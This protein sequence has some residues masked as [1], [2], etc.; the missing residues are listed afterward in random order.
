VLDVM[1]H[2]VYILI[3]SSFLVVHSFAIFACTDYSIFESYF[4]SCCYLGYT[5]WTKCM[6]SFAFANCLYF[7]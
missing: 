6:L 3:F 2:L 4:G 1:C 5:N 7:L